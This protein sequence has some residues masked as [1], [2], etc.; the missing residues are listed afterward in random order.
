MYSVKTSVHIH[1]DYQQYK[2]FITA[3]PEHEYD[4]KKVYCNQRNVVELVSWGGVD[5]VIKRYRKPIFLNRVAYT[6]FRKGKAQRSYENAN[7]LLSLGISTAMPV[8]Y[9][10]QK[11]FGLFHTE[12]FISLC[13]PNISLTEYKDH[14]KDEEE[15]DKLWKG[16]AEFMLNAHLKKIFFRDNNSGNILVSKYDD[17]LHFSIVDI[18]RLEK[19]RIPSLDKAMQSFDQLGMDIRTL[20]S[21]LTYY[22]QARGFDIERCMLHV[23]EHREKRSKML[24]L[25]RGLKNKFDRLFRKVNASSTH[26]TT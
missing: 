16:L 1:K 19:G 23:L 3:I 17:S 15:A 2:D 13:V 26:Q 25:K 5:F 18:N 21:P 12:W 9:I 14:I 4:V 22:S 6:F 8:A 7:I 20:L 10:T 24:F 11:H